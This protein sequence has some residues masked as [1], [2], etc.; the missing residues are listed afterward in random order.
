MEAQDFGK[1]PAVAIREEIHRR[2]ANKVSPSTPDS[3]FSPFAP[4]R[5]LPFSCR[6]HELRIS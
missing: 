1:E 3:T 5:H 6:L 2:Y 4:H